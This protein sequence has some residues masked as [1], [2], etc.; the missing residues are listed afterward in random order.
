MKQ[1]FFFILLF[2]GVGTTKINAQDLFLWTN[3]TG[4]SSWTTPGNWIFMSGDTLYHNPAYFYPGRNIPQNPTSPGLLQPNSNDVAC[5]GNLFESD[6][7]IP[8]GM[9]IRVGGLITNDFVGNI[10]QGDGTR[11]LFAENLSGEWNSTI[12]ESG[13]LDST[14]VFS[15]FAGQ[16]AYQFGLHFASG[17]GYYAGESSGL[18]YD[19]L[20]GIPFSLAEGSIF[21]A[22]S[23]GITLIR[24]DMNISGGILH[25]SGSFDFNMRSGDGGGE[26]LYSS[27]R[28]LLG[29]Y[30]ESFWVI[31]Q[32]I[33]FHR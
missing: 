28:K 19:I 6:C 14:G 5:F 27:K 11:M 13:V 4:D 23:N 17:Y 20:I 3:A 30:N 12:I 7:Y 29:C 25:N 22:P 31:T 32:N 2:L 18:A 26:K 10:Y 9:T 24:H 15:A 8:E 21:R 33:K 1:K 16:N